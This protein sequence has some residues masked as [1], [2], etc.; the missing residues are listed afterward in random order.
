M[1]MS[2]IGVRKRPA[3][4]RGFGAWPASDEGGD[5]WSGQGGFN[6]RAYVG[7]DPIN[8]TDPLGLQEEDVDDIVVTGSRCP[9]GWICYSG[10]SF[11]IYYETRD[12][13]SI[14]GGEIG[15]PGST[16]QKEDKPFTCA[17]AMKQ[18]GEIQTNTISASGV[19][20][21]GLVGAA[22]TWS[23]TQSGASGNFVTFGFGA[24]FAAGASI[25][26]PSY[27]S[28]KA[29][30]GMS[31]GF[32]VGLSMGIGRVGVGAGYSSAWNS[33]GSGGGFTLDFGSPNLPG[34]ALEGTWTD[35]RISNCR[36]GP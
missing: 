25:T 35:T 13:G 11:V 21:L 30:T 15:R 26:K 2:N 31:D 7:A 23:N 3:V 8:F 5:K 20:G 19:L 18:P 6:L 34:V 12:W 29:F 36:S 17:D 32:S 1:F 33:S 9:T 28:I 22:G 4:A 16:P 10:L 24:G 14:L 27:S